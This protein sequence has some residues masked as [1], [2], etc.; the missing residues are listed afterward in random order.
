MTG[1]LPRPLYDDQVVAGLNAHPQ[2]RG[3]KELKALLE[4]LKIDWAA[5][6]RR[7]VENGAINGLNDGYTI[8]QASRRC[9]LFLRGE[10]EKNGQQLLIEADLILLGARSDVLLLYSVLRSACRII[11]RCV[12]IE[13]R[14][15][16]SWALSPS[17]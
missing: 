6:K 14:F 2:L 8:E 5:E 16:A 11:T 7:T 4:L 3:R 13:I 10:I 17:D 15:S 9:A 12:A 1:T